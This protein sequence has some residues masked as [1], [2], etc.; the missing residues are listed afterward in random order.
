MILTEEILRKSMHICDPYAISLDARQDIL[1]VE[2]P[3]LGKEAAIKAITEWGQPKSKI[4]HLIF[5]TTSGVDMPGADC[6]LIKLLGLEPSV[7]RLMLYYQGCHGGGIVLRAAKDIAENNH[8]AR[9]LA[10]CVDSIAIAF[11]GPIETQLD[12]LVGP[13]IFGDGAGLLLLVPIQTSPLSDPF[14]S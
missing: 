1:R 9:V 5:C 2:V 13:A 10:V 4:T 3:K 12:S 14:F 11:R 7:R 8:G 6:Q